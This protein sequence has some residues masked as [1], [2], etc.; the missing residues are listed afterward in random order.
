M[1]T[2]TILI[3]CPEC[4]KQ[5]KAPENVFGK[6]VRCKFCQAAFVAR[7]RTD[8]TAPGKK[9]KPAGKPAKAPV[10][11]TGAGEAAQARRRR[12]RGCQPLRFDRGRSVVALSQL[13]Q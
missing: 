4:G 8:A 13:R 2:P 10:S 12:R 9:E 7:P 11:K 1:A 3:V 5:I 6:K